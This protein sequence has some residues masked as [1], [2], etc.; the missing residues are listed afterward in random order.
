MVRIYAS[1]LCVFGFS[2]KFVDFW[3]RSA[4]F[5]PIIVL[6]GLKPALRI[7]NLGGEPEISIESHQ[8]SNKIK[9]PIA[10]S[11]PSSKNCAFDFWYLFG[12][13]K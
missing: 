3:N 6:I 9:I 11:Q 8:I 1:L 7:N 5:S 2:A 10:N 13:W 4:G 12:F